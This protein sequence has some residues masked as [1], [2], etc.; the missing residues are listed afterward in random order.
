MMSQN[1]K[2]LI[3]AGQQW[4]DRGFAKSV[5]LVLLPPMFLAFTFVSV[6][7]KV[8]PGRG[9]PFQP[10]EKLTYK[11][12]WG[13]IPAGELTLEVL[14]QETIYGID[15]HHFVMRTK[16]S[17]GVDLIYKVRERQDSY[18]DVAMIH[19][20]FYK[21]KTESQH[22]RDASINFNWEKMEATYTNFGRSKTPVRVVPGTFDPLALFYALRVMD[23]KEN[24]MIHIPVT[25]G[26]KV[27][28]EVM[29]NIGKREV[30]ELKGRMYDTI[31]I[32]PD[33]E[34]L[35]QL[36]N[37]VK[38]S[39]NPQLKIWVTADEKK[40]P[41]KIRTKVGIISFDFDLVHGPS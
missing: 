38:K 3:K 15:A 11:G 29:V 10:G 20:L 12:T 5:I 22:P 16:T 23:L 1:K 35:D 37:V 17:K 2:T 6:A 32:T 31:A 9:F 36:N 21:I 19:S 14:P 28:I 25:D 13:I 33:M 7:E 41:L 40:I 30:T 26:N 34:M 18:V 39:D 4:S 8:P 24:S 27:S